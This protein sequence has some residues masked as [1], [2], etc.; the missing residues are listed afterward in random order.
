MILNRKVQDKITFDPN[1]T[2]N[3]SSNYLDR[4]GGDL[5]NM[6]NIFAAGPV[7]FLFLWTGEDVISFGDYKSRDD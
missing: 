5:D 2:F 4:P 3:L 6:D 7:I 1:F